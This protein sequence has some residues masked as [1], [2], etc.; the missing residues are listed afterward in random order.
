VGEGDSFTLDDIAAHR[1][2]I[3]QY[4]N[5]VV[6]QQVDFVDVEQPAV[7][8]CQHAR[9]KVAL[10]FLDG[11]LDIQGANNPV[12]RSRNRQVNE[13]RFARFHR[14][15]RAAGETL[16][17]FGAPGGRPVGVATK[18]ATADNPHLRQQRRQRAGCS[19]FSRA[20][21]ATDENSA[22][23]RVDSVED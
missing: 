11:C 13:W 19:R 14:D 22:N 21:L 9:L 20:A 2:C 18:T 12:L 17:A 7:G 16:A 4:I 3:E 6:V 10:A 8:R 5:H 1:R 23:A 15:L